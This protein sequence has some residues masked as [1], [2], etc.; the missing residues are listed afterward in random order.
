MLYNTINRMKTQDNY[1]FKD[2]H[3]SICFFFYDINIIFFTV[4]NDD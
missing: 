3:N 2:G 4:V 1:I